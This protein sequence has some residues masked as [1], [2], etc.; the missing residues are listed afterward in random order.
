MACIESCRGFHTSQRQRPMQSSIEFCIHIIVICISLV[1]GRCKYT[2]RVIVIC[3]SIFQISSLPGSAFWSALQFLKFLH[4]H[5]N[6]IGNIENLQHLSSCLNL[7]ILTMYDTPLS[8]KRNYRHHAVNSIWTLKALDNY[9]I[10]DEEIIEDAEFKG[11]FST[12]HPFLAIDLCPQNSQVWYTL[13]RKLLL[14]RTLSLE[15]KNVE[16]G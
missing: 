12:L 5:D 10:S 13:E 9:V 7:T 2:I 3:S 6:P 11:R 8:L 15:D 4:L 16:S 14:S 1:V